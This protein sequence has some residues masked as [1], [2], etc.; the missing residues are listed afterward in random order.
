M[1]ERR[2]GTRIAFGGCELRVASCGRTGL[3][4]RNTQLSRRLRLIP[5]AHPIHRI[6]AIEL[7]VDRLELLADALDVAVDGALADVVVVRVALVRALAA[8]LEVAGVADQ[9]LQHEELGDGEVDGIAFPA[10]DEALRVELERA[11]AL[12]LLV[13]A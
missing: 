12:D 11:D 4:T 10:D 2:R 5:V 13:V 9:R 3:A 8:R 1:R 7:R 6:D